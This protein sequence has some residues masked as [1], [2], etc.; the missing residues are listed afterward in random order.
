MTFFLDSNSKKFL[1]QNEFLQ[2]TIF[3]QAMNLQ[4]KI[5]L[6]IEMQL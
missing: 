1:F 2:L 4:S 5:S 6:N 3:M